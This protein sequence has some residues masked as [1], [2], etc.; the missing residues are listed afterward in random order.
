MSEF[1]HSLNKKHIHHGDG[2]IL[3]D[4]MVSEKQC[5]FLTSKHFLTILFAAWLSTDEH[6]PVVSAAGQKSVFGMRYHGSH[7]STKIAI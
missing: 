2:C 4:K 6:N 5:K 3:I 7:D 1:T